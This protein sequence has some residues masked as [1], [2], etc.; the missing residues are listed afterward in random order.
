M[1]ELCYEAK[2]HKLPQCKSLVLKSCEFIRTSWL[3]EDET[4]YSRFMAKIC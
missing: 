1:T 4:F 3:M 2:S